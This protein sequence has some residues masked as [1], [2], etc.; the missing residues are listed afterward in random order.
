MFIGIIAGLGV[1]LLVLIFCS[2]KAA[3]SEKKNDLEMQK[4][5]Q[6]LTA[7]VK[8]KNEALKEEDERNKALGEEIGAIKARL[9]SQ[10]KKLE[11]KISEE[12]ENKKNI[13]KLRVDAALKEKQLKDA[14]G[15]LGKQSAEI[16][17]LGENLKK[18]EAG[19]ASLNEAYNGLKEQYDEM[20]RQLL[21]INQE[22]SAPTKPASPAKQE[23]KSP[24]DEIDK[25][26]NKDEGA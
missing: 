2:I 9:E 22:K 8:E 6:E 10:N 7:Q 15:V 23:L 3:S 21:R 24:P 18:K 1:F 26:E 14:Q 13:D 20:E 4:I 19:F 17:A 11:N 16:S 5:M 25:P 12:A